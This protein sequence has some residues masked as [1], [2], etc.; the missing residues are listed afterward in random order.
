[1]KLLLTQKN[2]LFK[3]IEN[4]KS[5]SPIQFDL[6]ESDE[7]DDN[8][9]VWIEFKESEY[10]F[11]I[12]ENENYVN[13][14][15]VN[16]IPGNDIYKEISSNIR[17]NGIIQEFQQW[18]ENLAR[19]LNEPSYYWDN[20]ENE[21]ANTAFFNKFDNSKFSARE[22]EDLKNKVEIL[23]EKLDSISFLSE[24]L[25]EIKEEL[26]RITE[27]AKDLG[28]FDWLNLFVGT[29]LNIITQLSLTKE[30]VQTLWSVIKSIFKTYFLN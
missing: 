5:F 16:Y 19:E 3:F 17:W 8:Q 23:T 22:F 30:N 1:M 10:Y 15:H 13:S 7:E 28:K 21:L 6:E 25:E 12:F 11:V 27:L 14:F 24:Q 29:I 4:Q 2:Q 18:L 9:G 26:K 20:I